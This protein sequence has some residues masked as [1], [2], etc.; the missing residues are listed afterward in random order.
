MEAAAVANEFI[1]A[2]NDADWERFTATCSPDVV[3]EEKGSNRTVRG[4]DGVLEAA[5]GWRTAFPDIRGKI[6]NSTAQGNTA[7][8]E[9]TWLA[10]HNGPLALP[11]GT[12]PATGKPVEFDGVQMFIVEGGKVKHMRHYLDLLTMLSRVG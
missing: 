7:A 5:K 9:I 12:L 11:G 6:S 10:T 3:Y 2:F 1:E 4:I 8:L